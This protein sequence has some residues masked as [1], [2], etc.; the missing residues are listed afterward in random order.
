MFQVKFI[1]VVKNVGYTF[2][3]VFCMS[4]VAIALNEPTGGVLRQI[5]TILVCIVIYMLIIVLNGNN[6]AVLMTFLE[7]KNR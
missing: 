1:D 6:R 2:F 7:R 5:V 3:A 4:L